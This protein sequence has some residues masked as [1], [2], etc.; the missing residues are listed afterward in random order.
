MCYGLWLLTAGYVWLCSAR[1]KPT[2]SMSSQRDFL[3]DCMVASHNLLITE[4]SE[5]VM[6]FRNEPPKLPFGRGPGI[7]CS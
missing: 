1:L 4:Y 3:R 5:G 6:A 7:V 2:G